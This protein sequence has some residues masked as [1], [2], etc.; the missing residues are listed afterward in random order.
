[1][2]ERDCWEQGGFTPE[3]QW[4]QRRRLRLS[5]R[6]PSH[7]ANIV[8]F[9]EAGSP[10]SAPTHSA[11]G[12]QRAREAPNLCGTWFGEESLVSP[13]ASSLGLSPASLPRMRT[14]RKPLQKTL[15][16]WERDGS[17]RSGRWRRRGGCRP[18]GAEEG[19]DFRERCWED[20]G[21]VK[22]VE[23][24]WGCERKGEKMAS[25]EEKWRGRG[26]EIAA[27]VREKGVRGSLLWRSESD[28]GANRVA[29]DDGP[30]GECRLC[31]WSGT[32]GAREG[33]QLPAP[34]EG[35]CATGQGSL[36]Q[37]QDG[38]LKGGGLGVGRGGRGA[39]TDGHVRSAD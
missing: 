1:M 7:Y 34:E 33:M 27:A 6:R 14:L 37:S 18:E 5:G 23:E 25:E 4:R 15:T 22:G 11:L 26:W 39:E 29:S 2:Y 16:C 32:N 19:K 36:T 35:Y 17:E 21:G 12:A 31:Q 20:N 38:G 28:R 30:A 24:K 13:P 10:W 3:W 9:N 8:R